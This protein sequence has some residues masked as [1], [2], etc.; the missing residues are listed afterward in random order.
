MHAE[1]GMEEALRSRDEGL[2]AEATAL[3][4]ELPPVKKPAVEE[5]GS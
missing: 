5:A 3:L 2:V 4:D 1:R